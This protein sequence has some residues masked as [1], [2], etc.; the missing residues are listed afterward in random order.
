MNEPN[1]KKPNAYEQQKQDSPLP[2]GWQ[3]EYVQKL[4]F[5]RSFAALR[6]IRHF[7]IEAWKGKIRC[8]QLR[9]DTAWKHFDKAYKLTEE[10][11][12][13]IPNLV[14][15][16]V[17]NIWCFE[18]AIQEAPLS[19]SAETEL[20]EAWIPDLPEEVLEEYPEVRLVIRM[21]RRSEALLRVHLGHYN[22]AAEIYSDLIQEETPEKNDPGLLAFYYL[23]LAACEHNLGFEDRAL[24][25][26]ENASLS[27]LTLGKPLNRL[28][29][30]S[31][32]HAFYSYL[33]NREEA[34][35]WK[36]F[37]QRFDCPQV[38]RDLFLKKAS[39]LLQRMMDKAGLLVLQA[40]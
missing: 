15:Q 18:N 26:L 24:R 7:F 6:G 35:N 38:T 8:D 30:A 25:N 17:L 31:N 16:F 4:D 22:D 36:L 19:D 5:E 34:E 39:V 11:P 13:T 14:R 12:E 20:E 29:A 23:G 1:Q 3:E 21:R 37:L 32:L 33:E 40:S 10:S 2:V 9:F 27:V 28:Q